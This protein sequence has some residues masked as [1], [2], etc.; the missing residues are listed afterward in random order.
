MADPRSARQR[1]FANGMSAYLVGRYDAALG[2]IAAWLDATPTGDELR[3]APLAASAMAGARKLVAADAA[4]AER[5]SALAERLRSVS[6]AA[7]ATA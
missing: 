1:A 4:L 6:P 7:R 5:V 3:L 2:G